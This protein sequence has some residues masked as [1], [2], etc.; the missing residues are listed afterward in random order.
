MKQRSAPTIRGF[1]HPQCGPVLRAE[2]RSPTG[3]L[4]NGLAILDTGAS[5]SAV[6]QEVAHTLGL[7]SHGAARWSAV[8]DTG[9][10]HP[11]APLRRAAV[12][13]SDDS[14][15]WELDLIEIPRLRQAVPGKPVVALLGW[16][17]LDQCVLLC[18]GPARTF[19]LELPRWVSGRSAAAK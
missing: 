18:D 15:L 9:E 7:P 5:L 2:V 3:L 16:N 8:T 6:D 14:R 13:L 11:V 17:F 4:T 1:L 19:T 10:P 12:R